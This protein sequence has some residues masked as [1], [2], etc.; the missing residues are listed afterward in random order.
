VDGPA[1]D[2][3]GDLGGQRPPPAGLVGADTAGTVRSCGP[4]RPAQRRA[5]PR[6][7]ACPSVRRRGRARDRSSRRRGAP[8]SVP[9]GGRPERRG[10]ARGSGPAPGP[11]W[12][13]T[14]RRSAT[15][16]PRKARDRTVPVTVGPGAIGL[17]SGDEAPRRRADPDQSAGGPPARGPRWD[18]PGTGTGRP[19]PWGCRPATAA[20]R[21][22]GPSAG[23]RRTPRRR[24]SRAGRRSPGVVDLL[25]PAL[26]EHRDPV[27]DPERDPLVVGR[28][29]QGQAVALLE[30]QQLPLEAVAA[31]GV[32][33]A[34]R[35]VGQQHG[36]PADQACGRGRPRGGG[37]PT[38]SGAA[39]R[40]R[41]GARR[42]GPRRPPGGPPPRG[43]SAGA[44]GGTP[45]SPGRR[46]GA[47]GSPPGS[48]SRGRGPAAG[49]R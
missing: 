47:A 21:R 1:D 37:R 15:S 17:R 31:P 30:E 22:A 4:P 33:Q 8:R 19:R 41:R 16:A 29:H 25:D 42:P 26:A 23:R 49:R 43:G 7:P 2:P 46:G 24:S 32:H 20:R 18:V 3:V 5:P 14:S 40:A 9:R 48:P 44:G 6:A 34:E 35:L 10:P 38:G 39:V 27:G 13:S 45:G 12:P 36:D 28:D 11:S